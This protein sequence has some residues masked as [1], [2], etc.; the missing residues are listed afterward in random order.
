MVL[1]ITGSHREKAHD[2]E[3]TNEVI[4]VAASQAEWYKP[5]FPGHGRL[6]QEDCLG[7]ETSLNY[8]E[9]FCLRNKSKIS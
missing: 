1:N 7:F 8:G 5:I 2:R 9:N 4:Y 3:G 6:R